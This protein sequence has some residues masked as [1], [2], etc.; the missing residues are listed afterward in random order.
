M[1]IFSQLI[2]NNP[3]AG[4]YSHNMTS[5]AL[6]T[7]ITGQD[8]SYLLDFL[9][10]KGYHVH[11]MTRRV[12][13]I[14][15]KRIDHVFGHERLNLH[16]GD[17]SDTVSMVGILHLIQE[18]HEDLKILEVY[19]LGAQSHVKVS[20]EVPEFTANVSG[21]G[22]LRMLESIRMCG[23]KDKTRFYQASTSEIYGLVQ[24]TPQT[25]TTPFYPR[26]PYGAAKLYA[27]WITKN[28]RE[29][30]GIHAS[31]GILFNHESPRRGETFVTRK[32]TRA[33]AAIAKGTQDV[34]VLG[35]LGSLRDW[36][37]ARDYVRAMWMMLQLDTPDD[38]VIATGKQY[39]VRN[40]VE[41]CCTAMGWKIRWE[42]E[43]VD[44]VG[45]REDTDK[46]IV[47]VSPRYFR[48]AEVETLLGDPTKARTTFGWEPE[49]S[50]DDT[51]HDMLLA[52]GAIVANPSKAI[53]SKIHRV[54]VT[55]GSG[56]VGNAMK[57]LHP[58]WFYPTSKECNLL[59]EDSVYNHFK[60]VQPTH[61]LHLAAKVGGL[62]KNMR[63]PVEMLE[64]NVT[65][66]TNIIRA[67]HKFKTKQLIL[68]LSTCIF[69][70]GLIPFTEDDLHKGPPHDSNFAYAYG[71]RMAEIQARAY[72]QKY[73]LNIKCI[74]PTNIYGT[75]DNFSLEDS[76]VI[77]GLVHKALLA[78]QSGETC[79]QIFGTGKP[80]RQFIFVNDLARV[81]EMVISDESAPEMMIAAPPD[82]EV[83]ILEV[84]QTI[85][86]SMGL[87]DVSRD[88]S[89]SDG[90]FKKTADTSVLQEYLSGKEFAWT[91]L[92]EGIKRV[93]DWIQ[94]VDHFRK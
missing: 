5:V 63:E 65:M 41:R 80:L 38:Y 94:H 89:K 90:Q 86:T 39:S 43:G 59:D 9:L 56:L 92:H 16:F 55:G 8:G 21:L 77:P 13:S 62:Y 93:C 29:S 58:E 72:R 76:H 79:L 49:Y 26:S 37:D 23:L 27:H 74:V 81:L 6:I 28:Y 33:M 30:Y 1:G 82:G 22:T 91:P 53:K 15:T 24:E 83:S 46:V 47:K 11:G 18:K 3:V 17:L 87:S 50:I 12:S 48:P 67:C 68:C 32:I 4:L 54:L 69:P 75:H 14:N 7:G 42:G 78:K 64:E 52:D 34:L 2:I 25:E 35:N 44:E 61:V 31:N 45:I 60:E 19:N 10:E 57:A 71:K 84:A 66:N 70:D 73:N 36:G 40:F 20:F 88:E 85:V 51:I